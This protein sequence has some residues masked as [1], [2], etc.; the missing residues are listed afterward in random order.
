[1]VLISV[2]NLKRIRMKNIYTTFVLLFVFAAGLQAQGID[3]RGVETFI[4]E[5]SSLQGTLHSRERHVD[6]KSW[7]RFFSS[8]DDECYRSIKALLNKHDLYFAED[9]LGMELL[10]CV[11]EEDSQQMG[12]W[13]DGYALFIADEHMSDIQVII[14]KGLSLKEVMMMSS[15][16]EMS[17][18]GDI[19]I[20]APAELHV[21]QSDE[22][23]RP[24]LPKE[25]IMA[26]FNHYQP[27]IDMLKDEKRTATSERA[28]AIENEIK[29]IKKQWDDEIELLRKN[30]AG[31]GGP[32]F[33]YIPCIDESFLVAPMLDEQEWMSVQPHAREGILDWINGTGFYKGRDKN[34]IGKNGQRSGVEHPMFVVAEYVKRHSDKKSWQASGY[35]PTM[36][37]IFKNEIQG[38]TPLYLYRVSDTEEGYNIMVKDLEQLL[39][40]NIGAKY[41]NMKVTNRIEKDGMRFVQYYSP[42]GVVLVFDSPADKLCRM[43][44]IIGGAGAFENAVNDC[45]VDGITGVA[46]KCNIVINLGNIEIIEGPYEK[47]GVSFDSGVHFETG[48]WEKLTGNR[49]VKGERRRLR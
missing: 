38:G 48:Y 16:F 10:V 32:S 6:D 8:G 34:I 30:I 42:A 18:S 19:S 11:S 33:V 2:F 40:R 17:S 44:V 35:S 46:Q 47:N 23:V 25:V 49:K 9:F 37:A 22:T 4:K 14:A 29:A 36:E 5:F 15:G 24:L 41:N 13:G 7:A 31:L 21:V 27:R 43:D 1:M 39:C 45:T 28:A 12:F 20:E 3:K 26:L